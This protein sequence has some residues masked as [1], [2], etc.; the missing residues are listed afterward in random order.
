MTFVRR[1]TTDDR[2]E[3]LGEATK[4]RGPAQ[5]WTGGWAAVRKHGEGGEKAGPSA[6]GSRE[7]LALGRERAAARLRAGFEDFGIS[8][9]CERGRGG[10]RSASERAGA[11]C[12]RSHMA[13][14]ARKRARKGTERA[15]DDRI[16]RRSKSSRRHRRRGAKVG[17]VVQAD[18][19]GA[20]WEAIFAS[21]RGGFL[22]NPTLLRCSRR[23][24]ADPACARRDEEL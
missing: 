8:A 3:A 17:W 1:L 9:D 24:R 13:R 10:A 23:A 14:S 20:R 18:V 7:S 4:G 2:D 19:G 22:V 21:E 6:K 12:A 11:T 16:R 15:E 5:G